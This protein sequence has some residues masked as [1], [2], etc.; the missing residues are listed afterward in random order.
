MQYF[1]ILDMQNEQY[2]LLEQNRLQK[3]SFVNI[4]KHLQL[5][6]GTCL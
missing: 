1:D 6:I 3:S 5:L 2:S 4:L